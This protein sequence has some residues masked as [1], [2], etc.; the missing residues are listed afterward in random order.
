MKMKKNDGFTLIELL[1]VIGIIGILAAVI[2]TNYSNAQKQARDSS[3]KASVETLASAFAMYKADN[4]TYNLT[5][6]GCGYS[7][8]DGNGWVNFSDNDPARPISIGTYLKNNGYL[9]APLIDPRCDGETD[10]S[11]VVN[12]TRYDYM[13]FN[14]CTGSVLAS[15]YARLELP[16]DGDTAA[17]PAGCNGTMIPTSEGMNYVRDLN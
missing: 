4:K 3:R 17:V 9:S 10:T 1:V 5:G 15:I 8:G 13:T 14:N 11:C 6:K 2:V 16:S 12:S 7:T